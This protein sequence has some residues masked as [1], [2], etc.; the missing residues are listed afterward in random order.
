[1]LARSLY[2]HKECDGKKGPEL[3]RMCRAKG[4]E[5]G[6]LPTALQHGRCVLRK[7]IKRGFVTRSPWTVDDDI[8][9]FALDRAYIERHLATIPV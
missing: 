8:P 1:M 7:P 5:W 2:S 3:Q 4:Q 6:S 9:D